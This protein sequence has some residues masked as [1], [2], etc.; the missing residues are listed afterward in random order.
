MGEIEDYARLVVQVGVDV[1]EG[2]DVIVHAE[3]DQAPFV[4]AI[5][6]EAY[7]A[8][9]RT[10]DVDFRD[11][12]VRRALI[13]EGSEQSFGVTPASNLARIK[14]AMKTG[15]AVIAIAG[16]SNAEV[17]EG[18]DPARLARARM[19]EYER[20]WIE[21]VNEN[22][23]PWTIVAYP[24]ERWARE[25]FGEPDVDRLWQAVSHAMRLDMPD[26][27]AAWAERLDELEARGEAL[28]ERRFDAIRYRG[29]GTE[30]EVGLI[31]GHRW[32]A[33]RGRTAA[34]RAHVANM[35]T[36]EVFTSPH[37]DRAEGTVRATM[38]FALRGGLVEGLELRLS[39]GRIVEARATKGEDIVHSELDMDDGARRLGELALVDASS[40]VGD[41]GLVFRNTLFD[42]NAASHIAWG[43]G[44]T[45]TLDAMPAEEHKAAGLNESETH[46]DF[47]IGSPEVEV[48]GVERGGGTVPILRDGVWQLTA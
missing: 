28:T 1:Q 17:Y 36:E 42:E 21:A 44:L 41:T 32:L 46:T 48:D 13:A 29:P 38:P 35:P 19:P 40:R 30:L 12:Y 3:I 7:R 16:G 18:L 5:V 31:D 37:R 9:A 45:W 11:A 43:A 15:A 27:A 47:M 24:T 39:G 10:V 33:G 22:M 4:R 20:A 23:V 25:T 8:G 26:P 14:D 2:Q 34:G 6:A